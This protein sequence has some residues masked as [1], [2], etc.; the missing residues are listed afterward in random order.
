MINLLIK[1]M[2][3]AT[4]FSAASRMLTAPL[5]N[6]VA[7]SALPRRTVVLIHFEN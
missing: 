6:S 1:L 4:F 7:K 3:D 5:T 2:V